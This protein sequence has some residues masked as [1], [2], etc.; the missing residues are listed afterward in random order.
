LTIILRDRGADALVLANAE[1]QPLNSTEY[2]EYSFG[3]IEG[4]GKTIQGKN[5]MA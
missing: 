1:N 5:S 3:S 4:Q 2:M